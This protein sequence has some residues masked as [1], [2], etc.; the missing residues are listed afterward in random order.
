[1]TRALAVSERLVLVTAEQPA[2]PAQAQRVTDQDLEVLIGVA[3][4]L[5]GELLSRAVDEQLLAK[6]VKRFQD[7]KLL[8]AGGGA[9]DLRVALQN[10]NSRLRYVLGEQGHPPA[11]APGH[12]NQLFGFCTQGAANAF[13]HSARAEGEQGSGPVAVD[14]RAYQNP[15]SW[16][17]TIHTSDIPLT[18]QFDDHQR[19]LTRLA[20][21]H[22]GQHGGSTF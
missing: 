9:A 17:V 8:Q 13:L 7:A 20:R 14:G 3:A 21:A 16:E 18:Q 22:G 2:E 6:L 12:A 19:S 4:I 11:P 10:L 5:Q 15:A 1:M